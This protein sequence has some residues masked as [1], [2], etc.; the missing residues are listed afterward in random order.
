[1]FWDDIFLA[2]SGK[3]QGVAGRQ[4]WLVVKGAVP[5]HEAVYQFLVGA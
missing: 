5:R 1:M 3:E 2:R 4:C